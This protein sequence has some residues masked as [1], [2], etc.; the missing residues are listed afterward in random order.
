MITL[1]IVAPSSRMKIASASP[2]SDCP[3]QTL[4]VVLISMDHICWNTFR[5]VLHTGTVV[6]LHTTIETLSCRYNDGLT[7]RH[8]ALRR[9]QRGSDARRSCS[10][11]GVRRCRRLCRSGRYNTGLDSGRCASVAALQI[12]HKSRVC[13]VR[14]QL[15][16]SLEMALGL[17]LQA[18]A[19]AGR[20]VVAVIL[21]DKN[22]AQ[23]ATLF[24][25]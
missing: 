17:F 13:K 20:F 22:G 8:R 10:T 14:S 4:A 3:A 15:T 19:Q 5:S 24:L 23:L 21:V 16:H 9:R 1:E 7:G 18:V 11:A 6:Q 2:V 25:M 12:S